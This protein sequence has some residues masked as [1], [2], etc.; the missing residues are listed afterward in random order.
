[1]INL[2]GGQLTRDIINLEPLEIKHVVLTHNEWDDLRPYI[3]RLQ[4]FGF[5]YD[6]SSYYDKLY[7]RVKVNDITE[8]YL[9]S[10]LDNMMDADSVEIIII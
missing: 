3:K 2:S 6:V 4:K 7:I 10:I 9:Q 1:M 5:W 8:K